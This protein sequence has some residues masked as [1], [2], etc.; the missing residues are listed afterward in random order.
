MNKVFCLSLFLSL[1]LSVFSANAKNAPVVLLSIDGFSVKYIEQYKPKTLTKLT[2]QGLSSEGLVPVFPSKTFPNHLSIVTGKYPSEH[3]IIHNSFYRR[4]I[5][6]GY[7]LGA[8]RDDA[9]WLKAEPIWVTAEKQGVTSASYFWPESEADYDH[10]APTY[11]YA[12]DDSTPN[13]ARLAQ[14]VTW[15]NLP[16]AQRPQFI[17]SYFSIVDSAGH[18]F[19]PNSVETAESIEK[20]DTIIGDFLAELERQNIAIN[21]IIVSD[22]GML[23][24]NNDSI[25]AMDSLS[26][27]TD[28]DTVINGQTQLYIY[29]EDAATID[30]TVNQLKQKSKGRF[31]VYKNGQY[32]ENWHLNFVD[33]RIPDFVAAAKPPYTFSSKHSTGK[34][35]HGYNPT[36]IE[37]LSGIFIAKGPDIKNGRVAEFENIHVHA[38]MLG[39]LDLPESKISTL[40]PLMPYMA[41]HA[42]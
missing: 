26:L 7:T 30:A 27:S 4:D 31:E 21:L 18:T 10:V 42:H 33:E 24:I 3:G 8:G 11:R 37:G 12:F 19:G 23:E 13:E 35:T 38:F 41:Q 6:K 16:E 9:T 32:P 34:G 1:F 15:L 22:H 14:I 28:I 17:T 40:S 25:I 36:G 5:K 2:Q 29:E 39:L 20:V